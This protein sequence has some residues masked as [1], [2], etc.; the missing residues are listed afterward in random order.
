MSQRRRWTS[1]EEQVLIDQVRINPGNL[2]SMEDI[3]NTPYRLSGFSS[4]NKEE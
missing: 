3:E 1:E 2:F 4:N